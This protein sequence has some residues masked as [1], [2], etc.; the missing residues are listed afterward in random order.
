MTVVITESGMQFGK[1]TEEQVFPLEKSI[2]Y[3]EKLMP[4]GIKSCEFILR[5]ERKLYFVE[6]KSTCPR[7]ITAETSGEK[8][9]KYK[10]YIQEIVLKM[11]H[12]LALYS[13]ILLRRYVADGV[14]ETLKQADMSDL[15]IILVLVVK[16]AEKEWLVPFQDVFKRELKDEM[17]IWKISDFIVI[18]EATARAR[19]F[20]I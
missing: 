18:N 9:E 15:Q 6:A 14:S 19:H 1:Y 20:I 10:A 11:R 3:T 4:N 12:S 16:K 2:Q 8:K 7:Q 17:R 5:R 13:N